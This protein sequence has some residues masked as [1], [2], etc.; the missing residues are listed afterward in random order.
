MGNTRS[1][2]LASISP[3]PFK[4]CTVKYLSFTSGTV[5]IV[6]LDSSTASHASE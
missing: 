5:A 2:M 3:H 1:L 6:Q 4:S